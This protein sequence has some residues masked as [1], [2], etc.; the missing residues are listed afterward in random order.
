M[1]TPDDIRQQQE[2]L[3]TH[4]RTL[5]TYL[6]QQAALGSAFAPP[7]IAH[8]IYEAR[9]AIAHIKAVLRGWGVAVDDYPDDAERPIGANSVSPAHEP[10]DTSN[11]Q[12]AQGA[13]DFIN[14]PTGPVYQH[15]GDK[16]DGDKIT[17]DTHVS[18][19][20]GSGIAI[21]H[22]AQSQVQGTVNI[23]GGTVQAPVTGLNLGPV[24]NNPGGVQAGYPAGTARGPDPLA[25]YEVG[26]QTLR[27]RIGNGHARY[28]EMLMYEQRLRET[29]AMARH[30]GDSRE[31][32]ATRTEVIHRLNEL[33]QSALGV[34]FNELCQ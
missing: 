15:F 32:E 1:P 33:A 25:I 9:T 5:A 2:L 12:G 6:K 11:A 13:Q 7:G 24:N 14:R 19:V 29:I 22:K 20:S 26:L 8:G 23:S 4:R 28:N 27:T 21:G 30:Y 10:G 31:R 17:G 34:S 3:H 16:V 18:G